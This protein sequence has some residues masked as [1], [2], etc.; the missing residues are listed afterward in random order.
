MCIWKKGHW[1]LQKKVWLIMNEDRE[2][3][4]T[5]DD[6]SWHGTWGHMRHGDQTAGMQPAVCS[7]SPVLTEAHTRHE[8][9]GLWRL[10]PW[11]WGPHGHQELTQG[12]I[13]AVRGRL[14]PPRHCLESVIILFK[15][16][17]PAADSRL[18]AALVTADWGRSEPR[19]QWT[20][21]TGGSSTGEYNP[22][23]THDR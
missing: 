9:Q 23:D 7:V 13:T 3:V 4:L 21:W 5:L 8:T 2:T 12:T 19:R 20:R 22:L 11:W 15:V 18:S 6:V 1:F 17:P 14:L 10:R 16:T